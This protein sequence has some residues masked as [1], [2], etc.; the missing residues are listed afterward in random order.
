MKDILI[1]GLIGLLISL[2]ATYVV[3]LV[4]PSDDIQWALIAVSIA[5]FCAGVG[6]YLGAKGSR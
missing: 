2:V 5:G 3:H 6:G 4:L 1:S